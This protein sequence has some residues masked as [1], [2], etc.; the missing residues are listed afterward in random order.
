VVSATALP[1]AN[2]RVLAS[3][4]VVAE[5]LA[6]GESEWCPGSAGQR[7]ALVRPRH[8]RA[9]PGVSLGILVLAR[10]RL[11]FV[12][13]KHWRVQES[14]GKVADMGVHARKGWR[15]EWH[16]VCHVMHGMVGM[17]NILCIS[18]CLQTWRRGRSR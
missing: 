2:G 8:V 12:D 17:V 5:L 18:V 1:W 9:R 6:C 10:V 16:G 7:H 3:P 11:S 4:G 14:E 15:E 13:G